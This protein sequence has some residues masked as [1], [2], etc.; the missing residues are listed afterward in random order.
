MSTPCLL[1]EYELIAEAH[2]L[3]E[4]CTFRLQ[5]CVPYADLPLQALGK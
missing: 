4:S 5:W 3:S 1:P 2:I